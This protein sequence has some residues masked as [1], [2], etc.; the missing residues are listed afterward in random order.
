MNKIWRNREF[1]LATKVK[2]FKIF[3]FSILFSSVGTRILR[4]LKMQ[5]KAYAKNLT[6]AKK[7]KKKRGLTRDKA[8]LSQKGGSLSLTLLGQ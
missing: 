6:Y 5:K 3:T 4:D 1:S 8:S 2:L 7:G